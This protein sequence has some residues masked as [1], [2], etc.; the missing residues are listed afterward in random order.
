[1]IIM[2]I[3]LGNQWKQLFIWNSW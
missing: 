3:M 2:W 1:M